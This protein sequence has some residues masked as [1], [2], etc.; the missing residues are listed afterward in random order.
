[1]RKPTQGLILSGGG[2]D[3]AYEVGV[4]RAL[5]AGLSPST[6]GRPLDPRVVCGTSVGSINA[7]ALVATWDS[8][9]AAD[10]GGL[11]L[12]RFWLDR[13]AESAGGC[14][15]GVFRFR[16]DPLVA[17]DPRCAAADPLGT[18]TRM[19]R[20][21][22]FLGWVGMRSA[23]EV[24][25]ARAPLRQRLLRLFDLAAFVSREPLEESLAGFPF[26]AVR[27]SPRALRVAA[28][29][30]ATGQ[31]ATWDNADFTD[32]LG[33]RL[34]LASSAIP[35]FFTPADVAGEPYVDGGVLMNTPLR[36]AIRAGADEL[37]VVYLDPGIERIP[38]SRIGNVLEAL[39]RTQIIAWA[40][41]MNDD[42][43]DAK[44]INDGLAAYAAA[45][46]GGPLG[47]AV[48]DEEM[49][50]GAA[51]TLERL[52]RLADPFARY[53]PL[54]IHRYHPADELGGAL[55]ILDLARGRIEE[56]IRRGE[57]DATHHD[58]AA[59]GCVLPPPELLAAAEGS[60]A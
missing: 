27:E 15:N 40:E 50:R 9:D 11:W 38:L 23:A 24:L 46:G 20:D 42:V 6:G 32:A 43:E 22:G 55:G 10:A 36:P 17:L 34:L 7:A 18:A 16:G 2:A 28:T 41:R 39:Y 58:C 3:G 59:S 21:A 53:R 25:S 35:G 33:P 44:A 49:G 14:S 47:E 19:V 26:A 51:R 8:T 30:W 57:Q 12:E 5:A 4:A 56:L 48:V 54:T 13:L 37:H 60:A 31:L 1:M 45:R 29:N 52:G